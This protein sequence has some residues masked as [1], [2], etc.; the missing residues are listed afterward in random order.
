VNWHG[1]FGTNEAKIGSILE[2]VSFFTLVPQGV[3]SH[4]FMD[5]FACFWGFGLIF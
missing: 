5:F 3:F 1:F 4:I 2:G